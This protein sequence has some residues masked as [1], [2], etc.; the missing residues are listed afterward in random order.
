MPSYSLDSSKNSHVGD[1]IPV[2]RHGPCRDGERVPGPTSLPSTSE[3]F[4]R[5]LGVIVIDLVS[6][7]GDIMI[8]EELREG[9][10]DR[11]EEEK[12][13]CVENADKKESES[14][15]VRDAKRIFVGVGARALF[16]PTLLYNIVRN[17]VQAE[18]RWW[19][20]VHEFILLGAVPFPS[21]VPCLKVLGVGGVITLNE[22]YETLVPTSLYHA[23]DIDHLVI[24]TRDYCF[25]PSLNDISQAVAF[26]HEN[27]LSGRTTYVHCKAGRGRSTTIVIC[28]LVHHKQMTPHAAYNH[29]R[30][31]RPR[32]LLAPAQWKAVQ[33]YHHLKVNASDHDIKMTD[34]V[35]RTP[36][37][38]VLQGLVPFDDGTVVVVT[39]ADLDG[40]NPSLES[41]PVRS[42]IWTDLSV[43]C[44]FRVAGQAALARI[45][46]LW[47]Q[48][49]QKVVG[50]QLNRKNGCSTRADHL[51]AISVD[52]H[53]Y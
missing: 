20:R 29:L 49:H 28:Y 1:P 52:I 37:P 25:A 51:G 18:F 40:Y 8:I 21:D 47:L 9:E 36:R 17:K 14:L 13:W 32:V 44:R 31:I 16:Y 22:P 10:V 30:S 45:S 50:E 24:P 12:E 11:R 41:G 6:K 27:V 48:T 5:D 35:L 39:E 2:L 38:A 33:E 53:V 26:I 3:G 34:I 15:I 4:F 46:Y 42:E 7:F 23:Y 19:D 43:V